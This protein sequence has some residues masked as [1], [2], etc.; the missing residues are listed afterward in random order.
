MSYRHARSFRRRIE[1]REYAQ[2]LRSEGFRS[3]TL[4]E[5]RDYIVVPR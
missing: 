3:F 4:H 1:A 2:A 5:G